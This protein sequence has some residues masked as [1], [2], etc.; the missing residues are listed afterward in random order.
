MDPV[1]KFKEQLEEIR[2]SFSDKVIAIA[3]SLN[4]KM[5][6]EISGKFDFDL[7]LENRDGLVVLTTDNIIIDIYIDDVEVDVIKKQVVEKS[8]VISIE[9]QEE[10]QNEINAVKKYLPDL[11]KLAGYVTMF[12]F[13]NSIE[14]K[15]FI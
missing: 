7:T 5:N 10:I 12:C 11:K 14:N 13:A 2:E 9:K 15:V 3:E 4:M 8:E 6:S 1:K